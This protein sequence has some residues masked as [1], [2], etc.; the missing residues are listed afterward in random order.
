MQRGQKVRV[1][2]TV[3]IVFTLPG[4]ADDGLKIVKTE[5]QPITPESIAAT[6]EFK[7]SADI[8][9]KVDGDKETY[10]VNGKEVKK[11]EVGAYEPEKV[12]VEGAGTDGVKFIYI[13]KK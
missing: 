9:I 10:I 3:P 12:V 4:S 13:K 7:K 8:V 11:E 2:Y 1:K 5:S 6:E